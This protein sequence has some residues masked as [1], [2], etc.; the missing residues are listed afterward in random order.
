MF[1]SGTTLIARLLNA[2]PKI[3]IASDP[4]AK[5][6]KAFRN[7]CLNDHDINENEPLSDYFY[8][9]EKQR[10]LDKVHQI[11]NFFVDTGS[12][13]LSALRKTIVAASSPFSPL[14]KD[15]IHELKGKSFKELFDTGFKIVDKTYGS[16]KATYTGIKEVWVGEFSYHFLNSYKD[17]KVINIVRDPRGVCAS[18][19]ASG[20]SYPLLFLGR[21]WRKLACCDIYYR[22]Y[23]FNN[24][25]YLNIKYED[26]IT[27]PH[28][29]IKLIC[30]FLNIEFDDALTD[31]CN[32][33]DGKGEPWTQNS[34]YEKTSSQSFN[35]TTTTKWKETLSFRQISH[36]ETL[37]CPEMLYYGYKPYNNLENLAKFSTRFAEDNFKEK[38][39]AAWIKPYSITDLSKLYHEYSLEK[40]RLSLWTENRSPTCAEKKSNQLFSEVFNTINSKLYFSDLYQ[41]NWD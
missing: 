37:C 29:T 2:H 11:S 39:F 24:K 25:N 41:G 13:D 27:S 7:R 33:K 14:I 3:T 1:R 12:L 23:I 30:D 20:E 19:I 36:I 26:L 16:K 34:S 21:Q 32:F 15:H 6:F 40:N 5:L 17:S 28:S 10:Q 18:K 4:F 38:P 8:D 31:P 9:K 22:N 35:T